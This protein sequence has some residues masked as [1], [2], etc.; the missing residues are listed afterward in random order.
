MVNRIVSDQNISYIT[1][2]V[3]Y[4]L[5][6]QHAY[7]YLQIRIFCFTRLRVLVTSIRLTFKGVVLAMISLL[8][9]FNSQSS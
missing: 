8:H 2:K 6:K 3:I 4:V 7:V 9:M 5:N 1:H